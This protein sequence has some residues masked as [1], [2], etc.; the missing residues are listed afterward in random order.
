MLQSDIIFFNIVAAMVLVIH[1][2]SDFK[3]AEP[4]IRDLFDELDGYGR[5]WTL[6]SFCVISP[7]T[8]AEWTELLEEFTRRLVAEHPAIFFNQAVPFLNQ[9]D[10]LL[11]PL[12]LAYGKHGAAM[13][14][15]VTLLRD[16]WARGDRRLVK[17]CIAGLGVVGF[18]Y[19]QAVFQTLRA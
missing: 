19:P 17:R 5:L 7:N 4:L 8:P 18:Y 6:L 11:L 1:A 2:Y 16:G 13:T 10:I 9:F 14:E 15:I 12:G 3:R